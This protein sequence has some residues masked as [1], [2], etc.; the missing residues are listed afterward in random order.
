MFNTVFGS[1][2]W[3][4]WCRILIIAH[5]KLER[6]KSKKGR[7][8]IPAVL[9]VLLR[10]LHNGIKGLKGGAVCMRILSNEY[11][12][13]SYACHPGCYT[14]NGNCKDRHNHDQ[15]SPDNGG[16]KWNNLVMI[17]IHKLVFLIIIWPCSTSA[18]SPSFN[19]KT[20]LRKISFIAK[21]VFRII[22]CRSLSAIMVLLRTDSL[23]L[24]LLQ[25][26]PQ[27]GDFIF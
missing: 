19:R 7:F 10:C 16:W 5:E 15:W 26:F 11:S 13:W 24:L 2:L 14:N 9:K 27:R 22:L 1:V 3:F 18:P 17:R 12:C 6:K 8:R 25:D 4:W 21:W 23:F 20:N